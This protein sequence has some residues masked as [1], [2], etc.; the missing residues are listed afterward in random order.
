MN[1]H[2]IQTKQGLTHKKKKMEYNF[3]FNGSYGLPI[4]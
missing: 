3:F 1:A 2:P 4:V